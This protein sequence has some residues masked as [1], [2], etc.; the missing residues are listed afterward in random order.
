MQYFKSS[1]AGLFKQALNARRMFL[2]SIVQA[3]STLLAGYKYYNLVCSCCAAF[4]VLVAT[5]CRVA[6]ED[7]VSPTKAA[8][9]RTQKLITDFIGYARTHDR[10]AAIPLFVGSTDRWVAAHIVLTNRLRSKACITTVQVNRIAS[11]LQNELACIP[12]FTE[13]ETYRSIDLTQTTA[14]VV[15]P[16][17]DGKDT[18][19]TT[20]D[21]QNGTERSSLLFWNRRISQILDETLTS[22][23]NDTLDYV[24]LNMEG[25]MA[26][27]RPHLAKRLVLTEIQRMR[28]VSVTNKVLEEKAIPL[29]RAIFSI[30]PNSPNL[31]FQGLTADVRLASESLDWQI[32]AILEPEQLNKLNDLL[33]TA[34]EYEVV[35]IVP[36]MSNSVVAT[37]LEQSGGAPR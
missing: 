19:P 4:I 18:K 37:D 1:A 25:L 33:A 16:S 20:N 15:T 35:V 5:H 21:N 32:A 3:S 24:Y 6:A 28:I 14:Q 22:E 8:E 34:K 12:G 10:G 2:V 31:D 30:G 26:L 23:Q 9:I 27:G 17:K 11:L 7:Q 13:T 36:G 29:Q